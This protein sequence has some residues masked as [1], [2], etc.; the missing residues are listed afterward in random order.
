MSN[1]QNGG[2]ASAEVV[3][4]EASQSFQSASGL[5]ITVLTGRSVCTLPV[6]LVHSSTPP[7]FC[8]T[9][10]ALACFIV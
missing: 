2:G 10:H 8:T 9:V 5:N 6:G 1:D 4:A 7:G 3:F